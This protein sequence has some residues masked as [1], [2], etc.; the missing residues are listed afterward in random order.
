MQVVVVY[1]QI[2]AAP[3]IVFDLARDMEIHPDTTSGDE[4]VVFASKRLLELDDEV[5]FEARHFG[6]RH[7]LRARITE[8]DRPTVFTDEQLKGPFS[9]MRHTHR[10]EQDGTGTLMTDQFTFS[11][12]CERVVSRYMKRFL[13][14]RGRKLAELAHKNAALTTEGGVVSGPADSS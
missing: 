8:Y 11:A 5:E 9:Q 6:I 13:A 4:R 2:D 3:E 12:P 10:F 1:T 14:A 7:R